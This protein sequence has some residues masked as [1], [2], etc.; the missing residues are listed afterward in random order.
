MLCTLPA[1]TKSFSDTTMRKSKS[2]FNR[3]FSLILALLVVFS[4]FPLTPSADAADNLLTFSWLGSSYTMVA[5]QSGSG[6]GIDWSCDGNGY[7]TI[8]FT[9]G[10]GNFIVNSGNVKNASVTLIGGGGG[11]NSARSGGG[12][13]GGGAG[14]VVSNQS[15]SVPKNTNI[16][17]TVGAGG[18]GGWPSTT[19]PA[20]HVSQGSGGNGGTSVFGSVSAGGGAGGGGGAGA[21]GTGA[22]SNGGPR[23]G[24]G[25]GSVD[26]F[27]ETDEGNFNTKCY[28]CFIC[29]TNYVPGEYGNIYDPVYENAFTHLHWHAEDPGNISW[30]QGGSDG[31]GRGGWPS[32]EHPGSD[33]NVEDRWHYGSDATGVGAGGGGGAW[34][35]CLYSTG[36][37][38]HAPH[39]S[40][41][42]SARYAGYAGPGGNGSGGRVTLSGRAERSGFAKVVKTN[43]NPNLT[44]GNSCYSLAGAEFSIYASQSDANNN[45]NRLGV[46]T[47]NANGETGTMELSVDT[48]WIRETAAP[49]GFALNPGVKSFSIAEDQT[50]TV[51][52]SD[53]PTNDPVPVVLKKVDAAINEAGKTSGNMSLENAEFTVRFYGGQ[54]SS[55]AAAESSGSPLRT[56]VIKTDS[57]GFADIRL[58]S[59]RVSGDPLY[60]DT[61]GEIVF[62]IGTVVIFENKAP[63]G[64][65][66]NN[67]KYCV[68][69]SEDG[70][71]QSVVRTYNAPVIPETAISGGVTVRKLDT[72]LNENGQKQGD[73]TLAGAVF[74]IYNAN[75]K[76]VRVGGVDYA[77]GAAVKTITTNEQ[78]VAA[79]GSYDLPYGDYEIAETTPPAGYLLNST[80]IPFTISENGVVV[81]VGTVSN[82]VIR[83][84]ITVQKKDFETGNTTPQGNGSFENIEI[85]VTNQSPNLIIYNGT[86]YAAGAVVDVIRTNADGIASI[87]SLPY[88]TYR[89]TEI[90]S[91]VG[92]D[93]NTGWSKTV[94]VRSNGETVAVADDTTV[95]DQVWRGGVTVNKY[96]DETVEKAPQGD[97][98]LTGAEITIKNVSQYPV[99]VNGTEYG[100]GA[101]VMTLTTD[102]TGRTATTPDALPFGT[103]ELRETKA[104]VGYNLNSAWR[105]TVTISTDGQ[106]IDLTAPDKGVQDTVIRGDIS[107]QK[108]DLDTGKTVP[109]GGAT[110]EGAEIQI[111]NRSERK[112]VYN[113]REV[114]P[115]AVVDVILT[116]SA[117]IART[118]NKALPYGTYE[119]TE[120]K[121][122][123]G[124]SLNEDWKRTVEVRE[125]GKTYVLDNDN[126]VY[127]EIWRG[128]WHFVKVDGDTMQRLPY[129]VFRVT[130]KTTGE[131]HII[132]TD[133]N[134]EFRSAETVNSV[135]T[136][137][138][139]AAVDSEDNVDE[140]L[141]DPEAGVWFS[142]SLEE[143]QVK[144]GYGAFP[145]D[146]YVLQELKTSVNE[147]LNR[148]TFEVTIYKDGQ[149][150]NIGT[151]DDN[152]PP[153]IR[154]LLLDNDTR[155]HVASAEENVTLVDEIYYSGVRKNLEYTVTGHL[156]DADTGEDIII[157]GEPATASATF[158]AKNKEGTVSITYRLDATSLAGRAVVSFTSLYYGDEQLY[159]DDNIL[160]RDETVSFPKIGTYAHGP[161]DEKEFV[162]AGEITVID[163]VSYE[164]LTPDMSYVLKASLINKNTG[165]VMKDGDGNEIRKEV[166]FKPETSSG[167][168]DVEFIIDTTNLGGCTLVAFEQL[169]RNDAV[170]ARHEDIN[171]GGQTVSI[172]NIRTT[173]T[174]PNGLHITN[175]SETLVLTDTIT[176]YGLVIGRTYTVNGTLMDKS[177]GEPVLDGAGNQVTAAGTFVP[178][179][180]D[181]AVSIDFEFDASLLGGTAVVAFEELSND[182]GVIATHRI[183]DDENQT[184]YIPSVRTTASDK[185]GN[186]EIFANGVVTVVD[187]V[188][189]TK[190]I[191]GQTYT[192]TGT[193][194]NR[195]TGETLL[196]SAGQPYTQSKTFRAAEEDGSVSLSFRITDAELLEGMSLVAFEELSFS[197][198]VIGEHKDLEDENQTV[199][200]PKIRTSAHQAEEAENR[201]FFAGPVSIVDTVTYK[202]LVP[203]TE[204]T[205]IGT[206]KDKVTKSDATDGNGETITS[207]TIFT[208]ATADGTVDLVFTFDATV[209]EGKTLVAFEEL[210]SVTG[211]IAQHKDIDD[212]EQTVTIPKIRTTLLS[213][214]ENHVALADN[215]IT[216]TD[217]ISYSNL[218]PG[219]EYTAT[220]T[221]VEKLTGNAVLDGNDEPVTA[222]TAFTPE[223]A[224]G[225]VEVTFVFNSNLC[226]GKAIVAFETVESGYG[227]VARHEDLDD[228]NQTVYIPAIGTSLVNKDNEKEIYARGTVTLVDTVEYR[229]I[230]AG[231]RYVITGT[232]MDKESGEPL[233]DTEGNPI[234]VSRTFK[235]PDSEGTVEITFKFNADDL[236][237]V[238]LV[239]FEQLTC[240]GELVAK[241]EDIDDLEQTVHFPE[242]RTTAHDENGSHEFLAEETV[243]M[244]DT[245]SYTNLT[246]GLEYAVSGT[247]KNKATGKSIKDELGNEVTA[248]ATF[249]PENPD[250]SVD[251]VFTFDGS[252]LSNSSV[253]AFEELSVEGRVVADHS[254]LTDEDQTITFPE[255]GTVLTSEAGE[256]VVY[257]VKDLVL[258]DV[259][260]YRNLTPGREY[261]AAGVLIDKA[262]ETPVLDPEGNEIR[263]E[264]VFVPETE[265]GS[266]TVTFTFD[267]SALEG[268]TVVA[269][270]QVS[271]EYGVIAVHEDI[272][273]ED[274][275]VFF[276]EI[277]TTASGPDNGKDLFAGGKITIRDVVY[278]SNLKP[279]NTYT[280]TG[281]L[282]DRDSGEPVA[283]ASGA[284][285]TA[286]TDVEVTV[287]EGTVVLTFQFD[288][289]DLEGK[290]AVVFERVFLNDIVVA[291]HEDLEDEDQT[292]HFPKLRTS[293]TDQFDAHVTCTGTETHITDTVAYFNLLPGETYRMTGT[294][295]NRDTGKV[296][297]DFNGD[298][299]TASVEFVPEE[300]DGFV[301]IE[302]LLDTTE[303]ENGTLVA[304]E[305]L[306]HEER[307]VGKHEDLSDEDQSV[308]FPTIRTKASVGEGGSIPV[309]DGRTETVTIQDTITFTNL[310]P[311]TRYKVSGTLMNKADGGVIK[312]E[313]GEALVSELEFTPEE[314]DGTVSVDFAV[315]FKLIDGKVVVVFESLMLGENTIAVHRDIT[316]EEQTI[317]V[318]YLQ[319]GFKYDAS[320]G[321][322]LAGA[323]F[324]ITDKGLTD[325]GEHVELLNPQT[326]VTD[327]NGYFFYSALPGHEYS[328]V[329]IEAPEGY[330]LDASEYIV[331]I[332]ANGVAT[333]DIEIPN[334]RGGTVV[335]TKTDVITGE[336]LSNC[337]ITVYR[338]V[339][340]D[341]ATE[342]AA[343]KENRSVSEIKPVMQRVE[344]FRQTTDSRGRIYFYTDETGSFIFRETATRSG[345]YLNEDEYSFTIHENLTITG[346]TRIT[347]VP[348]GTV[349]VKKTNTEGSPLSGAQLQFFDMYDRYLGQGISDAKGRVYFVSPG[350]GNYYFKEVKAP[351]GYQ[352]VTDKYHFQIADDYRITG[353][354]TLVNGRGGSSESKTGDNQNL[355]LW[356]CLAAA[357]VTAAAAAGTVLITRKRRGRKRNSAN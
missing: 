318:P 56:W 296:I 85:E 81:N 4:L 156:V 196:D 21:N 127:D 289:G 338:E 221:L 251:I 301:D 120:I 55:A 6:N 169:T 8:N 71:D 343:R 100:V 89:L 61:N 334:I 331:D 66:I 145:F 57:D 106:V 292:V 306:Y 212:T 240:K 268:V 79:T 26:N 75:S 171:D 158:K 150:V 194:M 108:R 149:N 329:E 310:V 80:R 103:Y 161:N 52:Y 132:V 253:V 74:T 11:G 283:D 60:T 125:D 49:P 178:E 333:G 201:E 322:G 336:P 99:L 12:G 220:G 327:A 218:V 102:A 131:S 41:T 316:S 69:I 15:V 190:L 315:P 91:P 128:D 223:S 304:F 305:R 68:Q 62:P 83:G 20:E 144:D 232:L 319:R 28:S 173:L 126:A 339:L 45:S 233:L 90:S 348:F 98:T 5:G 162:A 349:V 186:K 335:I 95:K 206:L 312:T 215:E 37:V 351:N 184:V 236:A 180:N 119:L 140:S 152:E 17:V 209:L 346:E 195:D 105:Q 227:V 29:G 123:D 87:S 147:E 269:F 86:R 252:Q 353:T 151:V 230:K 275:S 228:E 118:T 38:S 281:K 326:V 293:A 22:G 247:L 18:A 308:H 9:A 320:D 43:A 244:T 265:N 237:D 112:I 191:P 134:G 356:I 129:A 234:T 96:D 325:S 330:Q 347:N 303:L 328:I 229:M 46:L 291:V 10:S 59:S 122:P 135:N 31:G 163:T 114:A 40:W 235:A 27:H 225:T 44:A 157:N 143:N 139:D 50:T 207:Q 183:L 3:S 167:T 175:A 104:P 258:T 352:V 285:V 121:A 288:A 264:A 73:A 203:G 302:F 297:K 287:P 300:P 254:D 267:A 19:E 39:D 260:E 182:Y 324:R 337:E 72:E 313:D 170:I 224:D 142:G 226:G 241:H 350:P 188:V 34:G 309:V 113:G 7:F 299:V 154:T 200:F 47:T 217:T 82:E 33:H 199:T 159:L 277:R 42:G 298:A 255:I 166:T 214:E 259:I 78:G 243:T 2:L 261:T 168:V 111:V 256:H 276:P 271:N 94:Q 35:T 274:Q 67:T 58:S 345:Y 25:G 355:R 205:L 146:T 219:R 117:G 165:Q 153:H 76:T 238:T 278:Y 160:N 208:P 245:V 314:A 70:A 107:V 124:Y 189:Y 192:V 249:T 202:N 101:D 185:D 164:N 270:E 115:N 295:M 344:V 63:T 282:M 272:N 14:A 179:T 53:I 211:I 279:G 341:A 32:N 24:G 65:L 155:E 248:E 130:S 290:S 294:L 280:F 141:L 109:L 257:P 273:D 64:F 116:N 30:G 187:E 197:G 93:R 16:S 172:P 266:V 1:R 332:A 216:L 77:S 204:Y 222:Q 193:L 357:C 136:N 286:S 177:T 239:A 321:H 311:G 181:G 262:G 246:P 88:G 110:L 342:A 354:L 231:E 54:Y 133:M 250:G 174:D 84:N 284:E 92:Y 263:A 137:A 97:A 307:L 48:Y 23:E 51:S 148:V 138:N 213:G 242:I 36:N 176:Y 13:A 340:D 323:R 317:T 210:Y 198:E